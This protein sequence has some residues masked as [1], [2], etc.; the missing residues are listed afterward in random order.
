MRYGQHDRPREKCAVVGVSTNSGESEA[1][2][3]TYQALFSL[4]HRGVE[5]SGI[6]AN[7]SGDRLNVKRS[8]G[9]VRDVFNDSD[10]RDLTGTM[11]VGHNRYSTNGDRMAHLQPVVSDTI[12]FAF[13]HN[14]NIPDTTGLE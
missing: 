12:N 10:L 3:I 7:G 1:A 2:Q 4:Q 8:A 5:G 9:M 11:S 14:G 13:A 6:V